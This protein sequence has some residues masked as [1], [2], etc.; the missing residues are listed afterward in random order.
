MYG[1]PA[2]LWRG[3]TVVLLRWWGGG[4]GLFVFVFAV[5]AAEDLL[6]DVLFLLLSRLCGVRGV[7]VGGGV[8]W[9]LAGVGGLLGGGGGGGGWW[10]GVWGGGASLGQPRVK[11]LGKRGVGASDMWL[12][13]FGGAVPSR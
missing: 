7:A 10:G 11:I 3:K 2:L 9:G 13:V 5:S 6:E 12:G 4:L 8:G 1:A